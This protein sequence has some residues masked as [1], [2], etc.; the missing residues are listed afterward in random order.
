MAFL[1]L[2]DSFIVTSDSASM[3]AEA[4]AAGKP[5]AMFDVPRRPAIAARTLAWIERLVTGQGSRKN[6]RAST[7]C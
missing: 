5:V 1:A 2:A 7:R 3:L 6:Y 4:C